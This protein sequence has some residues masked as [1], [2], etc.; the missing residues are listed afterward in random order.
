M[1]EKELREA[2]ICGICNKPIGA[3]GVPLFYRV[4]IERYGLNA[5]ALQRQQGLTMVLGGHAP[6]A[7]VMGPNE[8]M[9]DKIFSAEVTVCETCSSE[10]PIRITVLAMRK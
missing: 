7:A 8:D 6:L 5:K 2:A 3:S 9:A 10:K 1:K 4:R